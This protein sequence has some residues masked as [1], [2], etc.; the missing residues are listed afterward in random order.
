MKIS[1]NFKTAGQLFENLATAITRD[2]IPESRFMI[3]EMD[4]IVQWSAKEDSRSLLNAHTIYLSKGGKD[5][6]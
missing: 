4:M 2:I 3:Y 6:A 1:K 5:E